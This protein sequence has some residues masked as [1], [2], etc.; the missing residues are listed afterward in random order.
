LPSLQH[1]VAEDA[2]RILHV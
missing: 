2:K 1:G